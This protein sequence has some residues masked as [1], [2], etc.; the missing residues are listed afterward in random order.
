MEAVSNQS[1]GFCPQV[2]SWSVMDEVL[3]GLGC[4]YPSEWTMA[5]EFRRCETCEALALVKEDWYECVFCQASLLYT[6]NVQ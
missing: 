2:E 3:R 1:T 4:V 5:C 6:Y